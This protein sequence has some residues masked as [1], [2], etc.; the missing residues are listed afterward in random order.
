MTEIP[1]ALSLPVIILGALLM[2]YCLVDVARAQRPL[3]VRKWQWALAI[4]LLLPIGPFAYVLF[5]K[6]SPS[7]AAPPPQDI[8]THAGGNTYLRGD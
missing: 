3:L 4:V 5:E 1:L 7:P 8:S 6:L 2:T